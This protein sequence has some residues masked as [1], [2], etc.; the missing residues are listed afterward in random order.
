MHSD[1]CYN[2]FISPMTNPVFFEDPRTL[3]EIRFI[4]IH[5]NVPTAAGG[6]DVQ[7]VAAQVRAALTER[8]SLVAAKDG[9][10]MSDNPFIEDGWADIAVGLKYNLYADPHSQTLLSAGVSYELPVGSTRSLQGNGDGEFHLYVTGGKQL[11]CDWH[12]IS[13]AG[14]RVPADSGDESQVFYW[15]NHLD[16]RLTDRTYFLAELN[17]YHWVNEGEQTALAGVEGGDLFNLGSTDVAG[18]DIV[19]GAFGL[20]FKPRCNQEL[21]VAWEVPLT[22]RRD[23]LDNRLTVDWIIR[24]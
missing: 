15:S 18:N 11:G 24:Y 8:L 9:Y 13:G 10:I 22:D 16:R 14:L 20:K 3:S 2:D 5:H 7:L 1:Y 21:G 6:N 12:W 17:W 19:T 23:L 4:F